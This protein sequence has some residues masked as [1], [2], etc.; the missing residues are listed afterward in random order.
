MPPCFSD[1]IEIPSDE[2]DAE[3]EALNIKP[4]QSQA[5]PVHREKAGKHKVKRKSERRHEKAKPSKD[6]DRGKHDCEHHTASA[7]AC[8]CVPVTVDMC[9]C[10]YVYT[11]CEWCVDAGMSVRIVLSAAKF[12]T[13]SFTRHRFALDVAFLQ[14]DCSGILTWYKVY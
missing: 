7:A 5:G 10:R 3:R 12:R 8:V 11:A 2:G 6:K 9:I 4:P 14:S 1:I 13:S